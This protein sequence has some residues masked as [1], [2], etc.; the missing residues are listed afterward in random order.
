MQ[1]HAGEAGALCY[2]APR[3]MQ[4]GARFF[5]VGTSRPTPDHERSDTR[6][7]GKYFQS[8]CVQHNGLLSCLAVWQ[9]Q[10]A[11]IE[12]DPL[13]L[14][15]ENLPEPRAGE[16]K[17]SKRPCSVLVEKRSSIL[18]LAGVFRFWF[19]RVDRVRDAGRLSF[20]DGLSEA[21]QLVE[22]KKPFAAFLAILL[23]A[24]NRTG[25]TRQNFP[26]ST[27]GIQAP[28]HGQHAI[29]LI[30]TVKHFHMHASNIVC[31]HPRSLA[32]SQFGQHNPIE[33]ISIQSSGARLQ[34]DVDV[35]V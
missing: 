17:Q 13:P 29:G 9:K 8:R 16:N 7:V 19:F 4:I 5:F 33:N 3:A 2:R 23:D 24:L 1:P 35:L 18:R 30:G 26:L 27:K 6:K 34:L 10:H 12:V 25:I 21:R 22:G 32:T 20:A 14:Q 31:C 28:N 11:P 15:R